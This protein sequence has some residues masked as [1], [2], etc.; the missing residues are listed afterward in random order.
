VSYNEFARRVHPQLDLVVVLSVFIVLALVLGFLELA[1]ADTEGRFAFEQR[2]MLALREPGTLSNPWGP[3]WFEGLWMNITALGSG[4]I[5][6][7]FSLIVIGYLM[8]LREWRTALVFVVALIGASIG[9]TLLKEVFDRPRPDI[10]PHMV[11]VS[12]LSFPSGHSLLAAVVYPTLGALVARLV[13]HLRLK[14]YFV[15]VS[16]VLTGLIGVSRVYLG[17]HYP[18]DVVAGWMLGLGWA[19]LCWLALRGLQRRHVVEPPGVPA[20]ADDGVTAPG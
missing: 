14:L 15:T 10:I 6:M 16:L 7:L 3:R 1:E 12:S 11:K 13:K 4:D 5:V 2:I 20:S 8:M 18:T 19:I 9:A 17:V